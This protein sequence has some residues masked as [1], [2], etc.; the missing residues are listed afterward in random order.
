[1][2]DVIIRLA[3]LAATVSVGFLVVGFLQRGNGRMNSTTLPTGLVVVTGPD[4][5]WCDRLLTALALSGPHANVQVMDHTDARRQGLS[6][7]SVPT[8]LVVTGEGTIALRRSG[9]SAL[10]DVEL[11]LSYASSAMPG[12]SRQSG[13]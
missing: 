13:S 3:L 1:M 12:R 6:V 11:L 5:R 9:P 4:C 10:H 2:S 8:A 7:R